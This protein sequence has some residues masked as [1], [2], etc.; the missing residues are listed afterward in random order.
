MQADGKILAGGFFTSI[1][2][3]PRN[4]IARLDPVTGLA[5]SFNP[6]ANDSV[7]GIALQADGKIVVGG[8]FT[9][10]GG[11][12]RSLFA[13]LSNDTAA[14]QQLTVTQTMVNWMVGGS[15]PQFRRVPFEYSSD[16]VAY[17]PLGDGTESGSNWT[18]TGLNL[19]SGQNF[20][21]RARGHYRGGGKN[22]YD[23]ATESVRNAF[24]AGSTPTP[25]PT[26]TATSTP[27]ATP[28]PTPT[29]TP[30]GSPPRPHAT[31]PG[32]GR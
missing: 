29:A 15:S 22:A 10:I 17:T 23:S 2:G 14:L 31:P 9:T 32:H 7:S 25:T 20:Y 5:D 4:R 8:D 26:P 27:S 18:L 24:I 28:T 19:P 21:V 13:R 12:P 30:D 16:N 11:Q 1:G 6:N 3:Q